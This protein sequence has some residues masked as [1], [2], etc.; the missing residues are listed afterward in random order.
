[1]LW[2]FAN[3]RV[4]CAFRSGPRF[5]MPPR[6]GKGDGMINV[7]TTVIEARIT[8]PN[9]DGEYW[10]HLAGSGHACGF[11]LGKPMS[12]VSTALLMAASVSLARP[13]TEEAPE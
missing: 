10:L 6:G 5:G 12:M 1:M 4:L 3:D 11:N 2:I 8:G 7:E 13:A 9:N